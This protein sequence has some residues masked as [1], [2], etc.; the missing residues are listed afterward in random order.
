MKSNAQNLAVLNGK[1]LRLD[2]DHPGQLIPT[3]NPF[4][5][6]T[7]VRNEI[8]AYGFRNPFTSAVN[9]QTGTIFIDDVGSN[10]TVAREE[11]NVLQKGGNYGWA[12]VEGIVHQNGYTDPLY[13]FAHS[14]ANGN[15]ITGGVFYT[16]SQF[17]PQWQGKYFL[18]DFL[19]NF[20]RAIDPT[21]GAETDFATGVDAPVHLDNS[22]DG[23]IYYLSVNGSVHEIHTTGT[24]VTGP[25]ATLTSALRLRQSGARY[26]SFT[27]TYRDQTAVG[28]VTLDNNDITVSG[29]KGFSRNAVLFSST[30]VGDSDLIVA[31]YGIKSP[32]G[33]WTAIDDGVFTVTLNKRQVRDTL[34]IPASPGVLGAFSVRI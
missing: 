18:S 7:T 12:N 33:V 6:S 5:G 31:T 15:A 23:G 22:P 19:G 16:G 34:G 29:P 32:S 14:G 13:A 17:P 4:F 1:I 3:D 24:D 30:P 25:Y 10:G 26:Y 8:W 21:T 11:V 9:P 2:V 28:A 27:V 20:I